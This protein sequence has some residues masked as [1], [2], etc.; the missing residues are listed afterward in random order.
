MSADEAT[1]DGAATAARK[2]PWTATVLTLFPEMFP[3]HLG[4]SLAGKALERNLWALRVL[5]IRD[6]ARDKH[7]SV[8]DPPFGGGAGMV[9]PPD[10]L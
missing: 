6:F 9:M 1:R 3:G 2:P 4:A 8:D 5:D 7:R 10:V